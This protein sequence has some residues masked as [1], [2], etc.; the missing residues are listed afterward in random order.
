MHLAACL[1]CDFP[2]TLKEIENFYWSLKMIWFYY[3]AVKIW[4]S[5]V[6]IIYFHFCLKV[7][8]GFK[9]A[10]IFEL[11]ES[12]ECCGSRNSYASIIS[13][14]RNFTKIVKLIGNKDPNPQMFIPSCCLDAGTMDEPFST[15][16]SCYLQDIRLRAFY[17]HF[18]HLSSASFLP[19]VSAGFLCLRYMFNHYRIT[20]KRIG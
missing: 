8:S 6:Q 12:P 15:S 3:S 10:V 20:K 5:L 19:C 1:S 9:I 11:M 16:L 2:Q 13:G 17:Q 4:W 14:S 7:N 18:I